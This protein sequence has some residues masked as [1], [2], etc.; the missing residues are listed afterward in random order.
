MSK[1]SHNKHKAVLVTLTGE[2]VG[3]VTEQDVLYE[4]SVYDF[5]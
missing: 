1:S 3:A 4:T 2:A 5:V